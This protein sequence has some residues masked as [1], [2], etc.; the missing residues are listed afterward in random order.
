MEEMVPKL[1]ANAA[2]QASLRTI[3]SRQ[4]PLGV[5]SALQAMAE[6]PDS[7]EILKA[8]LLPA[9]I[10]HGQADA[11]MPVERGREMKSLLPS[12]HYVELAGIGH[13]PMME[14]PKSVAEALRFFVHVKIK[15]VKLLDS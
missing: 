7:T 5:A 15:G 4:R 2:I 11:L 9:V 12:A 6:R 14:D 1:T 13:V 8:F 10:V 3:V